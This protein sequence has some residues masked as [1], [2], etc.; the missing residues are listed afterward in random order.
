MMFKVCP[1]LLSFLT[2]YS[3]YS[4]AQTAS[5][6]YA[7]QTLSN[8]VEENYAGFADK[9]RSHIELVRSQVDEQIVGVSTRQCVKYLDIWLDAFA[10]P[11]MH[12]EL[13]HDSQT[14]PPDVSA[15]QAK[16]PQ[17]DWLSDDV[18][19]LRLPSFDYQHHRYLRQ[20]I[21]Q[22]YQRLQNT[23]GLII[24]L[25]GNDGSSFVAMFAVLELI[26]THEYHSMWHVLASEDNTRYYQQLVESDLKEQSPA[27]YNL[28]IALLE[29]MTKY[30][31]TWIEFS[32]PQVASDNQL[33][34]LQRVFVVQDERVGSSA[35]EFILATKGSPKVVT[36]GHRTQ[37][38]LD[39]GVP[40]PH[41]VTDLYT[42]HIP[43]QKRIWYQQESIVYKG[44]APEVLM[45]LSTG[46][47]IRQLHQ[48]MLEQLE[49]KRSMN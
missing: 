37:G 1:L 39:Y 2:L 16:A 40:V 14:L 21:S 32:W 46:R 31:N 5:C 41:H 34:H 13:T 10:D 8:T 30:P 44:L 27:V 28:F 7:L 35:E 38:T 26:G 49:M 29:D 47:V 42:V 17:F 33:T 3:S 43:S 19:L 20:L 15:E 22:H 6:D 4:L 25:R 11:I 12:I 23:E 18:A 45:D 9:D 36:Y 24:D 48:D